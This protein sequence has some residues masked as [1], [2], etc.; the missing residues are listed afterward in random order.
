MYIPQYSEK[1]SQAR[2]YHTHFNKK[3]TDDGY[4][5][6]YRHETKKNTTPQEEGGSNG[7]NRIHRVLQSIQ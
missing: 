1:Q 2:V 5:L 7:G 6:T 4:S 3:A